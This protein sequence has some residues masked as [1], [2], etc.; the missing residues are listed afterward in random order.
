LNTEAFAS[1]A[2]ESVFASPHRLTTDTRAAIE[3]A[4]GIGAP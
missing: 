3:P 4:R 2:A 1:T